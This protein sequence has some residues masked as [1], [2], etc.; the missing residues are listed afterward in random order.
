MAF[1]ARVLD[2]LIASPGDVH[3]ARDAVEQVCYR[4]NGARSSEER[5]TLRP[6]RWEADSVPLLTGQDPQSVLNQQLV[7]SADIV[8]VIFHTRLGMPTRRAASGTVEELTR[9]ASSGKPVHVYFS[10]QKIPHDV[11]V[12]QLRAVRAF[13]RKLARLGLVADFRSLADLRAQVTRSLEY[14]V[15]S[16]LKS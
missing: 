5:V 13:K 2:V 1:D 4:W 12:D 10:T 8:I 15:H 6:R 11:D 16:I 7:D 3:D 9:M 14:D